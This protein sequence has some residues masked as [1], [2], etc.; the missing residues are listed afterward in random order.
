VVLT[1]ITD[2]CTPGSS[3]MPIGQ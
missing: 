3:H 2:R 1:H